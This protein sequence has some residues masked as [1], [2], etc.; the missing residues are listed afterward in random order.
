MSPTQTIQDLENDV[1][2]KAQAVSDA[3]ADHAEAAASLQAAKDAVAVEQPQAESVPVSEVVPAPAAASTT[4][5]LVPFDAP[6]PLVT[7]E[8]PT[9]TFD[10]ATGV[11]VGSVP[12]GT[13]LVAIGKYEVGTSTYYTDGSVSI[14]TIDLKPDEVPAA[15]AV[16]D[17]GAE[18]I[19]VRV[20]PSALDAWK[21]TFKAFVGGTQE[22]KPAGTYTVHDLEGIRPDLKVTPDTHS[23]GHDGLIIAGMFTGPD[24]LSYYRAQDSVAIDSW[25]GFPETALQ[26]LSASADDLT[27]DDLE[28]SGDLFSPKEAEQAEV[29]A[30]YRT[31]KTAAVAGT[32][33]GLLKRLGGTKS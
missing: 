16:G 20:V 5:E 12:V 9:Q 29:S 8:D 1:A 2:A 22:L 3:Q 25:Y 15:A 21:G 10:P 26:P 13:K 6:M 32:T 28:D 14:K 31:Q 19:P 33:V 23:K 4:P 11:S 17:D 7:K 30:G 24:N 27:L 18:K